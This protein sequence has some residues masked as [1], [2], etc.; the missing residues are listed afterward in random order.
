MINW[1]RCKRC[2]DIANNK[3]EY[4]AKCKRKIS[5]RKKTQALLKKNK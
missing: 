5:Q 2:G 1:N 3:E 4:C